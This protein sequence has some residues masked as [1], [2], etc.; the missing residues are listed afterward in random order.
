MRLVSG[1]LNGFES[2]GLVRGISI[3]D[4][5]TNRDVT[6]GDAVHFLK[7]RAHTLNARLAVHPFDGDIHTYILDAGEG[8]YDARGGTHPFSAATVAVA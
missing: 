6:H 2:R 5:G 4:S 7:S 8:G 3:H 1:F